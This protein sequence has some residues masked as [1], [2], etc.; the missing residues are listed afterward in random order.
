M[1][2]LIDRWAKSRRMDDDAP[3]RSRICTANDE[4]GLVEE[5]ADA[6]WLTQS[7]SNKDD[8]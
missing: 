6:M 8:D 4:E 2:I 3:N 1:Q 5:M 7:S